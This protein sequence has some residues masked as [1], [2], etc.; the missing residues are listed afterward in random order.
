M[1]TFHFIHAFYLHLEYWGQKNQ[2]MDES[3]DEKENDILL[4]KWV[5]VLMGKSGL[6]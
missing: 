2:Y 5:L 4:I 3:H 1:K 6:S